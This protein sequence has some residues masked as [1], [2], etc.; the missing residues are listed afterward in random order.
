LHWSWSGEYA[1]WSLV[2]W[3]LRWSLHWSW[4]R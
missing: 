4:S 1:P 2:H 3:S